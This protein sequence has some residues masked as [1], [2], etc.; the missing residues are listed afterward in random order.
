MC[1]IEHQFG[2]TTRTPVR[3]FSIVIR[4]ILSRSK[5]TKKCYP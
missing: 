1:S 5:P 3:Y 2:F 4:P